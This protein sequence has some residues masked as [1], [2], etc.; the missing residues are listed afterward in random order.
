MLPTFSIKKLIASFFIVGCLYANAEPILHQGIWRAQLLRAD[1]NDIV[2]NLEVKKIQGKT[3]LYVLNLPER[4]LVNDVTIHHD[5]IFIN[6]PVFES[7]F[8]AKIISQDSLSG[9]WIK[10]G[11]SQNQE[12][13]FVASGKQH[14]RFLNDNGNAEE[15]IT[16][17]WALQ[18]TRPNG[19]SSPALA[20]FKQNGNIVSGSILTASGDYRYLSGSIT[21]KHL[22]LSNFDGIHA[23]YISAELNPDHTISTG[24]LYSGAKGFSKFSAT[25]DEN[26]QVPELAKMSLKDGEDGHLNFTFNDLDGHPVSIKDEKFRNKVVILQITGSWC[27]NCMDETAYLSEYYKANKKRGIEIIALAYELSTDLQRSQKSLKKFQQKFNVDYPMLITG[28]TAGDSLATEKTLPELT[29]IANFPTS[30]ILDKK[31]IVRKIDTGFFGPG[32][33]EFYTKYKQEFESSINELLKEE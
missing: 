16:G 21:N 18:F 26:A 15:N 24:I 13:P 22:Q 25:K 9:V 1:G 4:M 30:I 12:M 14:Y 6:M 8:K 23:F 29:P 2:F 33:G 19:K 20:N 10:G 7:S 11:S 31:G 5:S 3:V 27:P 32:T 17:K 28:V